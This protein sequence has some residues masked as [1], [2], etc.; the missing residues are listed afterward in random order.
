MERRHIGSTLTTNKKIEFLNLDKVGIDS[1][2]VAIFQ[3]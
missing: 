2:P 1:K 3:D